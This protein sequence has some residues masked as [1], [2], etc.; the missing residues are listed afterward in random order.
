MFRNGHASG[1][2]RASRTNE[3][4]VRQVWE[5]TFE[6]RFDRGILTG[7]F[8]VKYWLYDD[9][10]A[11]LP[12]GFL[13]H[14]RTVRYRAT[15][16]AD[17][18]GG[19]AVVLEAVEVQYQDRRY[20]SYGILNADGSRSTRIKPHEDLRDD[21]EAAARMREFGVE[22]DLQLPVGQLQSSQRVRPE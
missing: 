5:N 8:T 19:M 9:S 16:Q 2:N 14:R 22:F 21:P 20:G 3:H 11:S 10:D 17:A 13:C 15:G 1:S 4:K 7:D 12:D 6:G 18:S